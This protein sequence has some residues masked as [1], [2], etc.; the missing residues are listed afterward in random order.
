MFAHYLYFEP[1]LE[2]KKLF[3]FLGNKFS[4]K[5]HKFLVGEREWC[6]LQLFQDKWVEIQA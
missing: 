6:N 3:N 5:L 4:A 2:G 1:L